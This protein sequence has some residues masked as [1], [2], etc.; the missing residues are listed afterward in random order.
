MHLDDCSSGAGRR[1]PAIIA[2]SFARLSAM[3]EDWSEVT[4]GS[5]VRDTARRLLRVHP[6]RA[7]DALQ[8]A[9]AL[10]LADQDPS[11]VSVVSLDDRLRDAA[12][13]EGF[14]LV[15]EGPLA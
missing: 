8:L 15:P 9:A 2:S 4:P 10:V 13:R 14:L 1:D 7:A 5:L 3:R 12:R 6:L 11:S